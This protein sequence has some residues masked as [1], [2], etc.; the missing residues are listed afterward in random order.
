MIVDIAV[1]VIVLA[2]LLWG[3]KYAG[4]GKFHDDF[5]SLDNTKSLRGYAAIGVIFHHIS[6]EAAFQEAGHLSI[7]VNMG[8]IFV[9]IFFFCSGYG[10][11]KNFDA[12]PDYMK[13]FFKRRILPVLVPYYV[14]S[15]I[16][17]I[18]RIFLFH[19]P[20]PTAK[21]VLG[22]LGLV[23][24]NDY[25]W[26]PVVITTLYLAFYFIFKKVKN[27]KV[28]F[29]LILSVIL[30]E[31]IF[32]CFWGHFPWWSGGK[33][34]WL[35]TQN[36]EWWKVDQ[37]LLFSGEWWVNSSI[38]FFIGMLFANNES[39]ITEWFKK[40]YW[41]K[42]IVAFILANVFSAITMFAQMKFGYWSE[43]SGKGPGIGDK[44]ICYASQLPQVICVVIFV[45]LFMM[46]YHASNPISRFFGKVSLETYMMNLL[47]ITVFR[48]FLYGNINTFV[49]QHK[50]E[51]YIVCVFA[52]TVVLALIYKWINKMVLKLFS[53][54]KLD[55][56]SGSK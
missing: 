7:Y 49:Y 53:R 14:S 34:W 43:Y 47:A 50:F 51:L 29:G 17:A 18:V 31:G 23:L 36:R 30:F 37:I 56:P 33:N 26:F 2:L 42:L 55:K 52:L 45:F 35:Y 48:V 16:Y 15:V 1:F 5:V 10:L 19:E 6:Q 25:A 28:A 41:A 3:G 12:K 11:L 46:K 40:K 27:R 13:G 44:L 54:N 39:K 4:V 38:A 9:S 32:F 22:L 21:L 24:I 20:M 8:Y